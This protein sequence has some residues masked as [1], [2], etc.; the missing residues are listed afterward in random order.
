MHPFVKQLTLDEGVPWG[1]IEDCQGNIDVVRS[2]L[3]AAVERMLRDEPDDDE[4]DRGF[5]AMHV[6]AA[7]QEQRLFP[8]LMQLLPRADATELLGDAIGITLANVLISCFDGNA[9]PL[10]ATLRAPD[11]DDGVRND[12]FGALAY[13]TWQGRIDAA[14]TASFL[15]EFDADPPV[16]ND[17][18]S[19]RGWMT[20]IRLLGLAELEIC[21]EQAFTRRPILEKFTRLK[22]FGEGLRDSLEHPGDEARFQ[23]EDLGPLDELKFELAWLDRDNHDG[24]D[25]DEAYDFTPDDDDA[26]FGDDTPGSQ[27]GSG[28]PGTAP[29]VNPMRDVGRNDPCPCG[30]GKK[31]KRCCGA[32]A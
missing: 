31:Y 12:A 5:L 26:P 21:V 9:D 4:A 16:A 23:R 24:I 15:A 2:E 22:H 17:D 7:A 30:S 8:L 1:A 10:F 29:A 13:L 11:T 28:L 18:P 32:T 3:L 27:R 25:D 6:L 14:A 20:A 19:W